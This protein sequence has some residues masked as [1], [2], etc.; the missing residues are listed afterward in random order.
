MYS[1]LAFV[2]T[3]LQLA[4]VTVAIGMNRA[5]LI[6]NF[7]VYGSPI[8]LVANIYELNP[9]VT[10]KHLTYFLIFSFHS[11]KYF[12]LA[13]AFFAEEE[14][15]PRASALVMEIMYLFMCGYYMHT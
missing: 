8:H 9:F 7:I 10:G 3:L 12:F 15:M 6:A 4:V 11:F 14:N 5:D 1:M 2:V 13:R